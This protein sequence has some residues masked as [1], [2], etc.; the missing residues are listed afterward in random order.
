MLLEKQTGLCAPATIAAGLGVHRADGKRARQVPTLTLGVNPISPLSM[1]EAYAT[2]AAHGMHCHAT[3][4][5]ARSPTRTA[6]RSP[7]PDVAVH[8]GHRPGDRR[9]RD[10]DPRRASSTAYSAH[11][12]RDGA[13]PPGRRQDRHHRRPRQ[14]LVR[15]LHPAARGRRLGRRPD[16][17]G[18]R[19]ALVDAQRRRSAGTDYHAGLRPQP[20]RTHL[21]DR[22]DPDVRATRR[23]ASFNKPDPTGDPWPHRPGA[24]PGRQDARAG[25]A[26]RCRTSA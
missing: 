15:R 20:A 6:S 8:P 23:S 11:R 4:D 21:E 18:Q 26:R 1:A 17:L 25:P 13:R 3:G 24:R 19:Q 9:R 22:H 16:R 5:P 14:R 10:R 7:V 12:R 2:F